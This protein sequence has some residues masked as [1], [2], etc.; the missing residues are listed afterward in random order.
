MFKN[1][2]CSSKCDLPVTG[3]LAKI[4]V[5]GA[6]EHNL[7]NICFEIPK[8]K[9]VALTG[10]SG[11]GKSSIATGILQ[12]ECLRQ[13]LESLGMTTDHPSDGRETHSFRGGRNCRSIFCCVLN[14]MSL[15]YWPMKR[16]IAIK[17]KVS[18]EQNSA[19]FELQNAFSKACNRVAEIAETEKEFNRVKLHNLSYYLLRKESPQLG[20]QMSCNA[21][22]KVA[23]AFK[24]TKGKRKITFKEKCSVHFD[25]R[26][27]SLKNGILSLFTLQGRIQLQLEISAYHQNYL[28]QGIAKEA[29]LICKGKRWFFNLVL[30]LPEVPLIPKGKM[31]AIDMGEN[32]LAATS[33][34]KL[35]GGGAL[36]GKRDKFLAHRRRLQSNGSQ[37]AKQRLR[38]ISGRERRHVKHVNHCVAKTLVLEA[39][40]N[41]SSKIVLEDL[42]NIR[43]RIKGN[44]RLRCRLHR[45]SFD[46]LRSFI[47]YKAQT[48]G[49]EICYVHPA[50]TSQTCSICLSLGQR[51]K[52]RFFCFNCGSLQ[53]SDLNASRNLL[54]LGRSADQS[55]GDVNHRNIADYG[56]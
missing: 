27:Y 33:T 30:E 5:H 55:T 26:T 22:A 53:H 11:S 50:Y 14:G 6:R 18:Q 2:V 38:Q 39:K 29:E 9:L 15:K 47:E 1:F 25:K 45:W 13:Y 42:K 21:I 31:L 40:R 52:H 8:G 12:K 48:N 56:Q 43:K 19:F 46:E 35:C 10:P 37:S 32:N 4:I 36:K 24:A 7:K 3:D 54:R 34:G 20:S 49:I 44:K 23:Q 41:E 16:T 17:L 28:N 51:S